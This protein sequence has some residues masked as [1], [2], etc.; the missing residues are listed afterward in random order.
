M[1][2]DVKYSTQE[3]KGLDKSIAEFSLDRQTENTEL[4]A[5]MEDYGKIKDRCV[6]QPETYEERKRRRE[7]EIDGL[8]KALSILEDETALTQRSRKGHRGH[9]F[10]SVQSH[11]PRWREPSS[12]HQS[13]PLDGVC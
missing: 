5:V 1:E 13:L 2:Q 12:S 8:K 11:L 7:P 3:F 4:S 6:A 9:H 10:L